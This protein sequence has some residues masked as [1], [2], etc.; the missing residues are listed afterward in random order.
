MPYETILFEIEVPVAIITLNRPDVRNAQNQEMK[1]E[2]GQA[3]RAAEDDPLVRVVILRGAGKAFSSGHDL[4]KFPRE[5]EALE[6]PSLEQWYR[7]NSLKVR[8]LFHDAIVRP[9]LAIHDLQKT[10]IAQVH[11]YCIAGGWLLASMCDLIVA[12]DD[13][14]FRDPVVLVGSGGVELLVEPWDVGVR[15]AKELMWT[16]DHLDA[17]EALHLGMVSKVVPREKLEEETMQLAQ[18]IAQTPPGTVQASKRSINHALDLRGWR[19]SHEFH[20]ETWMS[21]LLSDEHR[22]SHELLSSGNVK[23]FVRRRD[24]PHAKV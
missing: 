24:D 7:G 14:L 6:A 13:T 2:L 1:E 5:P 17:Q 15:K 21:C 8:Q 10:T 11:G 16:G 3:F 9:C 12:S 18:K 22:R 19:L 4:K 23:E 20:T